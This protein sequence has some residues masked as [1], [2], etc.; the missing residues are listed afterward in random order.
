MNAGWKPVS[1]LGFSWSGW[2]MVIWTASL[3]SQDPRMMDWRVSSK[4]THE[5]KYKGVITFAFRRHFEFSWRGWSSSRQIKKGWKVCFMKPSSCDLSS[6]VSQIAL[7][8][9]GITLLG[10]APYMTSCLGRCVRALAG[11]SCWVTRFYDTRR[12]HALF[13]EL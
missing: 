13:D 10:L 3:A 2:T 1:V 5:M 8:G 4:H 6:R 9:A 12:C 7:R 11:C